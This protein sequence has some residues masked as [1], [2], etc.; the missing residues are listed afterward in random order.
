MSSGLVSVVEVD[1]VEQP[2]LVLGAGGGDVVA[3]HV[4]VRGERGEA[5]VRLGR[6]DHGQEHDVAFG[7][8][9]VGGVA[10]PQVAGGPLL[11]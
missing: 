5:A 11:G 7:A 3:L 2:H 6:G 9:E 10:A 8:L 1:R 4:Q